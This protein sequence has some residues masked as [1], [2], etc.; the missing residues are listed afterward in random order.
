MRLLL[1]GI[2][3]TEQH[4]GIFL[5]SYNS[6]N[7]F[8][9]RFAEY[10]HFSLVADDKKKAASLRLFFIIRFLFQLQSFSRVSQLVFV[11]N[12]VVKV[13]AG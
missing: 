11:V 4:R 1:N 7:G 3:L 8:C 5:H 6:L 12:L 13:V 2:I 10:P 9:V